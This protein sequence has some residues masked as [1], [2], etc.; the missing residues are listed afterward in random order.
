[1][2]VYRAIDNLIA[3]YAEFVDDG[4]FAGLGALLADAT[5]TGSAS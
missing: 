5:F 1:M 2:S 3:A 4:D